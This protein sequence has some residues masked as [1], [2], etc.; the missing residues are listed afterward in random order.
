MTRKARFTLADVARAIKAV[1]STGAEVARVEIAEGGRIV[2]V[3]AEGA[4]LDEGAASR[5]TSSTLARW[6]E[7]RERDGVH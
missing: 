3:T 5:S 4:A 7:E 6:L 1:R 2:V